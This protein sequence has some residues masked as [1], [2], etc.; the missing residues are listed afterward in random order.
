MRWRR[1]AT[2]CSPCGAPCLPDAARAPVAGRDRAA[3]AWAALAALLVLCGA[4]GWFAPRELLDWQPALALAQ[5]WR[6]FSAV[7]VHYSAAHLGVNL[8]GALLVGA[9]GWA[10]RV[11]APMVAAWA[12]AW[13]LSHLL[14][15]L[16][17]ELAH[18]GGLSGVL[19]AGVAAVAVHLLRVG[20]AAARRIGV[21]M[22][23]LLVAKVVS[24]A[25]WQAPALNAPLGIMVAPLA[26]AAGA[27]AGA[28]SA[29]VWVA[30]AAAA[31]RWSTRR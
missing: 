4:G 20:P 18:Y 25:P 9:L 23:V 28:A 27:T 8:L 3:A 6:W 30:L 14:L 15:G 24:E 22:A 10:A 31:H 17:P 19:H 11:N 13:P 1:S 7:G 16:Q 26:H 12:S 2:P 5:P 29:L 21:A